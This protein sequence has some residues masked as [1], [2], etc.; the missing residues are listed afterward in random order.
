MGQLWGSGWLGQCRIGVVPF[1]FL[2]APSMAFYFNLIFV[3]LLF[4][5]PSSLHSEL[6][7]EQ[8]NA[9]WSSWEGEMEKIFPGVIPLQG[10]G[11]CWCLVGKGRG[12]PCPALGS[13]SCLL[14]GTGVSYIEVWGRQGFYPARQSKAKQS[15]ALEGMPRGAAGP[16]VSNAASAQGEGVEKVPRNLRGG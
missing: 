11:G 12:H 7:I 16:G 4:F 14:G 13:S 6:K 2:R 3:P 9:L 15:Q 1:V 10:S 8:K 5:P